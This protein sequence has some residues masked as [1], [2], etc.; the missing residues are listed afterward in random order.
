MNIYSLLLTFIVGLFILGGSLCGI[1]YVKNKK[2]INFNISLIFGILISLLIFKLLPQSYKILINEIGIIR[3]IIALIILL[4]IGIVI[5][6]I[7]D[8]FIPNH[9]LIN[10]RSEKNY[11]NYLYHIGII[12]VLII[13][14]YNL[15]CGMN[16]YSVSKKDL[17]SGIMLCIGVGIYNIPIGLFIT[18][19]LYNKNESKKEILIFIILSSISTFIGGLIMFI[20]GGVNELFE[21]VL[22]GLILGMF[23]YIIAFEL[24]NKIHNNKDRKLS[25][26]GIIVGIFIIVIGF[27]LKH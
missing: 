26:V 25:I 24:F 6:K 15:M 18:T 2:F 7:I 22:Y 21:G 4:L 20:L 1:K 27:I 17:F 12:F 8:L 9:E 10:N 11:N 16:L 3:G 14:L 5:L 23:I 19:T 13:I